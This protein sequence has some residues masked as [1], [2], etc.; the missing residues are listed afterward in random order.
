MASLGGMTAGGYIW[1][2]CVLRE[3]ARS[4]RNLSFHLLQESC[5]EIQYRVYQGFSTHCSELLGEDR[6]KSHSLDCEH[7]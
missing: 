2:E 7:R 1:Q 3:Q 4:R 5:G 6:R